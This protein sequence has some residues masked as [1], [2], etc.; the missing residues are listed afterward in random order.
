MAYINNGYARKKTLTVTYGSQTYTYRITDS[1]VDTANNVGYSA[2][3]DKDFARMSNRD[4]ETRRRAFILYVYSL[5]SGLQEACPDLTLGSYEQ[6]LS[7]C[8]ILSSQEESA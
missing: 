7:L 3:L 5:H 6:N 1:F 2:L 8:P 4:Y